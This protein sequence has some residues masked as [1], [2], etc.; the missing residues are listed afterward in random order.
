MTGSQTTN[1]QARPRST[2]APAS[3][4]CALQARLPIVYPTRLFAEIIA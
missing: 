4:G 3:A 2:P 1:A